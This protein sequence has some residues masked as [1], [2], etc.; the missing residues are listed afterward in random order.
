MQ[1]SQALPSPVSTMNI[2]IYLHPKNISLTDYS[3][4]HF[5]FKQKNNIVQHACELPR[6]VALCRTHVADLADFPLALT[7]PDHTEWSLCPSTPA[8]I[9][10]MVLFALATLSHFLQALYYRKTYCWVIVGSA[11]AQTITYICRIISIKN[12]NNLGPYAAWF[13]IILVCHSQAWKRGEY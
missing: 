10:F 5:E 12:P 6:L 2:Y 9:L 11:L 3:F 4:G 1:E 7:D 13:V 8:A